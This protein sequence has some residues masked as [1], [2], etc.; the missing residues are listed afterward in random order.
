VK[1]RQREAEEFELRSEVRKLKRE[2]AQIRKEDLERQ[3]SG[4]GDLSSKTMEE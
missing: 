3:R 4:E 2:T 1:G